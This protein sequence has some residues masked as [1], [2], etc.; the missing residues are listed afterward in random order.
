MARETFDSWIPLEYSTDTIVRPNV[1]SVIESALTGIPMRTNSK[2]TPRSGAA[3]VAVVAKGSAYGEDAGANDNVTL[4]ARKPGI[5]FRIA[6]EDIGDSPVD[7]IKIKKDEFARS[8][9]KFMDNA[10]VGTTAAE[11]GTTVPYTSIY[12]ALRTADASTS[13][14]A[15]ANYLS[16]AGG[17]PGV[18]YDKLSALLAVVEAGDW[19]DPT[20]MEIWAAPQF[21]AALRGIKDANNNPIFVKGL[22]GTPDTL[23]D[24]P[25]KWTQGARATATASSAPAGN[26]L[27]AVVNPT[28]LQRGDRSGPEAFVDT[29]V[30]R[31]TDETILLMRCR[32]AFKVSVPGAHAILEVLP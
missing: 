31:L 21:R 23:F 10:C 17:I 1:L 5:A 19:F 25:V 9:A 4:V 8:Y 20:S 13:Y 6:N 12:K 28:Y 15:D 29:S 26:P 30:A 3:S 2:Q 16:V 14:V 32:K 11:N 22:A 7:I 27:M 24:I 18:T